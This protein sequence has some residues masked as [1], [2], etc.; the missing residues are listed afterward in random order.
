MQ[1]AVA[2]GYFLYGNAYEVLDWVVFTEW[3]FHFL[4]ALALLSLRKKRPDLPRPFVSWA[5]PLFPVVYAAL[6]VLVT[7]GTII[8]EW[9]KAR[10]GLVILSAGIV[11]YVPWRRFFAARA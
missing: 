8:F 11:I 1:C 10:Y 4:C 2:L 3:I 6:A 5:Y 7:L 9:E